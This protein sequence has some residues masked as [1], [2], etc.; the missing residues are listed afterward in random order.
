MEGTSTYVDMVVDVVGPTFNVHE[1]HVYAV[2]V[3]N[4]GAKRFY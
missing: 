3:P 2:D 4:K 1:D